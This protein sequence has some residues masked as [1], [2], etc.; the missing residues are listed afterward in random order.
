MGFLGCDSIDLVL[1]LARILY[2]DGKTVQLLD[3]T[4]QL[5]LLRA[6]MIL[7]ESLYEENEYRNIP[8]L[9]GFR[10]EIE[11]MSNAEYVFC[12]FGDRLLQRQFIQCREWIFVTDMLPHHAD[13]FRAVPDN[14]AVKRCIIRNVLPLKY[15]ERYLMERMQQTI[16]KEQ[17]YLLPYDE[18]DYKSSCYLEMDCSHKMVG[19]SY[20][21]KQLLADLAVQ[22]TEKKEI[23]T[24]REF[25]ALLKRA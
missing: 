9:A 14:A 7:E 25:A 22:I 20:E 12:Y 13:L 3:Y 24:R 1:Y 18:K 2:A 15:D 23:Y 21:M 17:I 10:E 19:L 8:I 4:E 5:L 11:R 6:A 16:S